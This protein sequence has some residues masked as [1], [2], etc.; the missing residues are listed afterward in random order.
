MGVS[1]QRVK[2]F[3]SHTWL[4]IDGELYLNLNINAMTK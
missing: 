3:A 2:F 1:N 4:K